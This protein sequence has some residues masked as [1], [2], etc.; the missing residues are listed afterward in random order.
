MLSLVC[1]LLLS[2]SLGAAPEQTLD[3][4]QAAQLIQRQYGGQILDLQSV[5]TGEGLAYRVK[6]L[7][8][9]GRVKLMLIDARDG[10]Q[11]PFEPAAAKE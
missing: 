11:R 6:L 5:T 8:P 3:R 10:K 4:E 2:A 7:Q 1:T 9:S